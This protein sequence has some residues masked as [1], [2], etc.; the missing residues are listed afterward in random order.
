VVFREQ[1][2]DELRGGG[3]LP[4]GA[5]GQAPAGSLDEPEDAEVD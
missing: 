3:V 2:L 5:H 1:L 4:D